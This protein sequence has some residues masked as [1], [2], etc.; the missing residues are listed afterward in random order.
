MPAL[1]LPTLTV[2]GGSN[3]RAAPARCTVFAVCAAVQVFIIASLRE[4]VCAY[5]VG[6]GVLVWCAVAG[7]S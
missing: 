1:M 5:V 7:G 6:V 4:R 3:V 2:G